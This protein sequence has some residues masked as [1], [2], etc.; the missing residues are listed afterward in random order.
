MK[1]GIIIVSLILALS[2]ASLAFAACTDSDG[3]INYFVKGTVNSSASTY[4]DFCTG[5]TLTEF[6]CLNG[7]ARNTTYAC[8]YACSNGACINQTTPANQTNS[9]CRDSDGGLNYYTF[10]AVYINGSSSPSCFDACQGSSSTLYEC[11]CT[12]NGSLSLVTYTCPYGC[13]NGAC[14]NQTTPTNQTNNTCS[15]SD[16]G[17]NYYVQGTTTNATTSKTDSCNVN[18]LTEYYCSYGAVLSTTYGCPYACSNGACIN[19]T[20]PANQTNCTDSDGGINYYVKGSTTN[21][22]I[23]KTDSCNGNNLTEYY[24]SY[25]AVLSTTYGCPYACSNGA[26]ANQTTPT[27]QTNYTCT[28]SDGGINFNVKGTTTGWY[29]G[30]LYTVN[31]SCKEGV[32]TEY[33][34]SGANINLTSHNCPSGCSNG[35]CINQTTNTTN[36]TCSDSDGG[37]NYYLQG[38]TTNATVSHTDACVP[39]PGSVT[40]LLTEFYCSGSAVQNATYGCPNGC[41]NGACITPAIQ[42]APP[43]TTRPTITHL[44]A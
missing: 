17:I 27:N 16:G 18:N 23:S 31:D 24:C 10:G 29:N 44:A 20:T 2:F 15:D 40:A 34:C 33:Y 8:P 39:N 41:S 11:Y 36:S 43:R 5:N 42:P 3:G 6:Y 30:S 28:D 26:C 38:T 35:A 7:T 9:T 37:I 32:L 14:A 1:F 12:S 4:T 25:G 19:Q 13:S 21:A 22:T